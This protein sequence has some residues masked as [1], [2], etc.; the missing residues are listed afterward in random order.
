MEELSIIFSIRRTSFVWAQMF[1]GAHFAELTDFSYLTVILCSFLSDYD[2]RHFKGQ[3][4]DQYINTQWGFFKVG[5][6]TKRGIVYIHLHIPSISNPMTDCMTTT[7]LV[8]STPSDEL[9]ISE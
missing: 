3:P 2:F 9:L 1:K 7:Y 6:P 4:I 8:V 5:S